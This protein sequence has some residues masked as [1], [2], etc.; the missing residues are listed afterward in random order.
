MKN[1]TEIQ[2]ENRIFLKLENFFNYNENCKDVTALFIAKI[3]EKL[4]NEFNSFSSVKSVA[5]TFKTNFKNALL[6]FHF[7]DAEFCNEFENE[8]GF[9]IQNTPNKET[10]YLCN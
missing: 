10:Y 5:K 4:N 6:N 2:I 8:T 3:A 9:K 7:F 1:L